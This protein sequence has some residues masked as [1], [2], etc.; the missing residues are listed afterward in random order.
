M[1]HLVK[2]AKTWFRKTRAVIASKDQIINI[3]M[4]FYL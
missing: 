3:I 2:K 4:F 1:K